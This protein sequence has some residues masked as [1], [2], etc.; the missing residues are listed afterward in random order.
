VRAWR[1][2]LA[3]LATAFVVGVIVQVFLAG[4]GLFGAGS[5]S[6]HMEFGWSLPVLPL[7]ILAVA[8]PA[9]ADRRSVL[10]AAGLLVLVIVQVSLPGLRTAAPVL[11]AF[12]PVNALLVFG[13]ALVVARRSLD[14]ARAG[15][16]SHSS[17]EIGG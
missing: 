3:A 14:L 11:A 5:M 7:A 1:Y 16:P 17:K 15:A 13:V 12:H 6:L 9:R 10:A 8:W 2:L 4:V